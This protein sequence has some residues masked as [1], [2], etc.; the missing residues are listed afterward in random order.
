MYVDNA[1]LIM[2]YLSIQRSDLEIG[3][4]VTTVK[5]SRSF[6]LYAMN[7]LMYVMQS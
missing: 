1:N 5:I 6:L 3:H 4:T 2:Q 7:E